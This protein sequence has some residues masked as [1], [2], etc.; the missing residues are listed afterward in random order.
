MQ[1]ETIIKRAMFVVDR[2]LRKEFPGDYHKRC[3]YAA[4][5]LLSICR[6][7]G[8]PATLV[9]GD[10]LAFTVSTDGREASLQGYGGSS[11][12][13]SHVWVEAADRILDLG[14][15]YLPAE[16][17]YSALAMPASMWKLSNEFRPYMRYRSFQTTTDAG[18]FGFRNADHNERLARFENGCRS[19]IQ[20]LFGN[21]K[22]PFWLV[23]G[24]A[25]V[26]EAARAGNPWAASAL[27]FERMQRKS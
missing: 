9:G 6:E 3:Y 18:G 7:S 21:P 10:L 27:R 12:G 4:A 19:R 15:H 2:E 25:S 8:L 11:D 17:R 26:E 16:S 24:P 14:I 5:A 13:L 22:L 20:N 23:E 1:V